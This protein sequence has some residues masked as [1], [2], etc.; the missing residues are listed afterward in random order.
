[1]SNLYKVQIFIFTYNREK[2]LINCLSS[3]LNQTYKGIEITVIDNCS[4]YDIKG[5]IE[6]YNNNK[7]NLIIN[8]KNLGSAESFNIALANLK[9]EFVMFFHDDDTLPPKYI[10]Q[11]VGLLEKY[12][13][14]GFVCS[15]LNN[16]NNPEKMFEFTTSDNIDYEL[17]NNK[18][19]M[20]EC[21]F[22]RP[23]FGSSS[24][25]FRKALIEKLDSQSEIYNKVNDR[26][27]IL[28]ASIE[29]PFIFL[30]SV[31]Y[32][33]LFHEGQDSFNR[34]WDF[35]YDINLIKLY[36]KTCYNFNFLKYEK[37]IIKTFAGFYVYSQRK[38]NF[39]YLLNN[40]NFYSIK[41]KLYFI[42]LLPL[43]ILKSKTLTYL[44]INKPKIFHKLL[45]LKK[46]SQ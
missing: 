38:P 10:E 17:F 13:H 2:Y 26:A 1:M 45:I 12:N 33:A 32:N 8:E 40:F 16:I 3:L 18:G 29:S 21:F 7:I 11:Q 42:F 20:L 41:N 24:I 4:N 36:L 43:W 28:R 14:V 30:K 31:K 35:N 44:K 25:L 15:T 9:N 37:N 22:T 27:Y 23:I 46:R 39:F 6:S 34:N 19:A 5:L